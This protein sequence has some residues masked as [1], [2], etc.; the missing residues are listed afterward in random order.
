MLVWAAW[1]ITVIAGPK[2]S[3][4][5]TG[6]SISYP[7]DIITY[8][9]TVENIGNETAYNVN[10][11]DTID[12]GLVEYISSTPNGTIT[13]NQITWNLGT[14]SNGTKVLMVLTVRVREAVQNGTTITDTVEVKWKDDTGQQYRPISDEWVTTI[15]SNPLLSVV[16]T[17]PL[18]IHPNQIVNYTISIVNLGGSPAHNVI[19]SDRLPDG[20]TY[21]S[22]LPPPSSMEDHWVNWTISEISVGQTVILTLR[23]N[24]TLYPRFCQNVTN[25][26]TVVWRDT[27]GRSYGPIYDAMT[28]RICNSAARNRK[29]WRPERSHWSNLKLYNKCEK[30]WW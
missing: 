14:L 19:I 18:N 1:N 15:L 7:G 13:G 30:R 16:K 21:V 6:P 26:V 28:T 25:N 3:I 20:V 27:I 29:G 10:V 8:T 2:L 23:V 4:D 17:G 24:M 5:K 11:T 9:I 12:L 22:A